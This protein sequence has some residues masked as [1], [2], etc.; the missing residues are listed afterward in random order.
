M[1]QALGRELKRVLSAHGRTFVRHGKGDHEIWY[2]PIADRIVTLDAGVKKH[3]TVEATPRQAG[4]K[5]RLG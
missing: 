2:S 1:G 4:I 3:F 5:E